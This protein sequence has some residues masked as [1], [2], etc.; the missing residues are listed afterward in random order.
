VNGSEP[1]G[2]K[3]TP[4]VT[5]I[6]VR[7]LRT[8]LTSTSTTI[9]N[10]PFIQVW[11]PYTTPINTTG[12]PIRFAMNNKMRI[13][14]GTG[15]NS[16][17]TN[18]SATINTNIIIRP[19]EFVVLE[20][21]TTSQTWSSPPTTNTPYFTNAVTG[22][23]DQTTWPTFEFYYNNAL[24]NMQRRTPTTYPTTS[25]AVGGLPHNLMNFDS[26]SD[27]YHSSFIPTFDSAPTWRFVG[28]PRALYTS[29]YDWGTPI[30]SDASYS[31]TSW[32]GIQMSTTPR[33]QDFVSNWVNRDFIRAN[34]SFGTSP[35]GITQKPSQVTSG[36]QSSDTNNAI[37]VIRNGPMLSIGELGHIFDPAQAADDL[38]APTG[39]TP[40]TPFVA[41][42]GRTL[43]I[44]QPEFQTASTDSWDTNASNLTDRAAIQLLDLFSVNPTNSSGFPFATGRIN[45]NTAPV[46]VLASVLAGI[47]VNSDSGVA[48]ANLSNITNLANTIISNRPYNKFSD[49]R[50]FVPMFSV[51]TNYSPTITT[52]SGGGTTNLA[53]MDRM[54]EEAFGKLVQHLTLQSRTYRVFCLGEFL[55]TAGRTVSKSQ[56]EAVLY[57]QTNSTGSFT[58]VL[59]WKKSL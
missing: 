26:T 43:R 38:T 47:R 52:N 9:E 42:G 49:F 19:N 35:S 2:Q 6:A 28:D 54:R 27:R 36:F 24:V 5:A 3:L 13:Y 46:E 44:G 16:A 45:P 34:P 37:A 1:A 15:I 40:S 8:A 29:S 18:Y 23:S 21:P 33:W 58:P 7:Y 20:F 17:F 31:N 41:G 53:V 56:L 55:N 48:A 50:K 10:Q 4:H 22:S 12:I 57:F 25:L 51:G 14:F 59:Q 30:S 39:G 11:N 32:K